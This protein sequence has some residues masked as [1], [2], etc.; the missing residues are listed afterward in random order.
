[1]L[2]NYDISLINNILFLSGSGLDSESGIQTLERLMAYGQVMMCIL[3]VQLLLLK[4]ILI[5]SIL[6]YNKRRRELKC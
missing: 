6:F 1:M 4:M 3:F 5:P 2:D